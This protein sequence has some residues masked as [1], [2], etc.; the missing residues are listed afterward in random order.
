MPIPVNL[1]ILNYISYVINNKLYAST[2]ATCWVGSAKSTSPYTQ[3]GKLP[4]CY[5]KE[6]SGRIGPAEVCA[7]RTRAAHVGRRFM[8]VNVDLAV[9]HCVST[10]WRFSHESYISLGKCLYNCRFEIIILIASFWNILNG[11]A[12][13]CW[14][15]KKLAGRGG[16]RSFCSLLRIDFFVKFLENFCDWRNCRFYDVEFK[17]K[18]FWKRFSNENISFFEI[19]RFFWWHVDFSEEYLGFLIFC[20]F[21]L[22]PKFS[23]AFLMKSW[24][25]LTKETIVL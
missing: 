23:T 14:E 2:M 15:G 22:S 13:C 4:D 24:F 1:N 20:L 17:K 3:R 21:W 5:V 6:V 19:C 8:S 11:F 25:F 9:Y 18:V 7:G 16:L 10:S 12:R